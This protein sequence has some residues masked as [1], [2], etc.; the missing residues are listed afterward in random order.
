MN[1][2]AIIGFKDAGKTHLG[3]ALAKALKQRGLRVA[4]AKFSD[5]GFDEREGADTAQYKQVVDAVLG[6]SGSESFVSWTGRRTLADLAPL[7][8]EGE[9][10]ADV[11]IVEGGK[12][13]EHL[14]RIV[15]AKDAG[16]AAEL[17]RGL[18]VAVVDREQADPEA[19]ADL[20]L[21][22]G[23]LLP[24]LDCGACG[25]EDCGGLARDIVAGQASPDDCQARGGLMT[26]RLDGREVPLNP[27][28][29]RILAS[30]LSGMLSELKG[31]GPGRVEIILDKGKA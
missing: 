8:V 17:D 20:V 6:L 19:L 2:I 12:E 13:Q 7:V 30:G 14:P 31:F 4:V 11:L 21:Q 24:G 29:A 15:I 10:G 3:L 25:R 18:A 27:F 22:R 9:R 23:F 28:V 5:C 26:V 1:A 16:D